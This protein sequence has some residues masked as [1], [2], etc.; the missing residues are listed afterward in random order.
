MVDLLVVTDMGELGSYG[1]AT[2]AAGA[3]IKLGIQ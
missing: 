1:M 3:P 2:Y